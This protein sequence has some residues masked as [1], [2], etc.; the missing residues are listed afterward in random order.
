M[1]TPATALGIGTGLNV[2]G[3]I[4]GA[5]G[6]A[7][8]LQ[9]QYDAQRKAMITQMNY[10][11]QNYEMQRADAFDNAVTEMM[12][13]QRQA[14]DVGSQAKAVINENINGRTAELLARNVEGDR[15]RAYEGVKEQYASKSNEIDL[16]EDSTYKS[17]ASA[18]NNLGASVQSQAPTTT[19]LLLDIAGTGLQSWTKWKDWSNTYK[20]KKTFGQVSK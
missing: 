3:S 13:V 2:I 17:T 16:N 7:K 11:L 9:A 12:N 1:C 20:L 14:Q 4:I 6:Q 5:R 18:I 19:N 8:A 15:A 10:Q